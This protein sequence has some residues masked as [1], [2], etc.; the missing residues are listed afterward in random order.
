MSR[1][2]IVF[3]FSYFCHPYVEHLTQWTIYGH[4][5]PMDFGGQL[6]QDSSNMY[7]VGGLV[8]MNFIFPS[9]GNLIIP[10]DGIIFFRGVA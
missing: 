5:R 7:L 8:A 10:I 6:L 2:M 4:G 1:L 3:M 9:I